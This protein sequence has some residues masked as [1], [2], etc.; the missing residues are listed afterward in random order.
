[1]WMEARHG[2]AGHLEDWNR[3]CYGPELPVLCSVGLPVILPLCVESLAG[4]THNHQLL[5]NMHLSASWPWLEAVASGPVPVCTFGSS[6]PLLGTWE[7]A[8]E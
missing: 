6:N 1:M 2:T 8:V 4:A 3:T 5:Y 7:V